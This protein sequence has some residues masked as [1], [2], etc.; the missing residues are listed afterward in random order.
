MSAPIAGQE[1]WSLSSLLVAQPLD[2]QL[3]FIVHYQGDFIKYGEW[4]KV[5]P[6][7]TENGRRHWVHTVMN[8]HFALCLIRANEWAKL[9][10]FENNLVVRAL[11]HIKAHVLAGIQSPLP[12]MSPAFAAAVPALPGGLAWQP[13]GPGAPP[14]PSS[15]PLPADGQT[16]EDTR[17]PSA[18]APAFE[19][20][21]AEAIDPTAGQQLHLL[22]RLLDPQAAPAEGGPKAALGAA[23]P[24]QPAGD[25]TIEDLAA[26]VRQLSV[27]AADA[28][29]QPAGAPPLPQPQATYQY[30][31]GRQPA[32]VGAL[33][34]DG[35]TPGA[36]AGVTAQALAPAQLLVHFD[37][38]LAEIRERSYYDGLSTEFLHLIYGLVAQ[39]W[40]DLTTPVC[41]HYLSQASAAQPRGQRRTRRRAR[42][43]DQAS[44]PGGGPSGAPGPAGQAPP[45]GAPQGG[46][47]MGARGNPGLY[48][49]GV[50]PMG[51]MMPGMLPQVIN[52]P[53]A[54][55]M[56]GAQVPQPW[57]AS[58]PPGSYPAPSAPA[59]TYGMVP[60]PHASVPFQPVA[61]DVSGGWAPTPQGL[62]AVSTAQYPPAS[63]GIP[64]PGGGASPGGGV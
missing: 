39:V 30:H 15:K 56:P 38:F 46:M 41:L 59:M 10:R 16:P 32:G 13:P 51:M 11:H 9:M 49:G 17:R 28:A 34:P 14:G 3:F 21:P 24:S 33:A 43:A 25:P 54:Q 20:G 42:P 35:A 52:I 7:D 27:G 62:A 2:I 1:G 37:S 44:W 55:M 45:M 31:Q 57:M 4:A 61:Q 29:A 64:P 22:S 58:L 12:A 48:G 26:S 5:A 60:H 63:G 47:G 36:G 23:G 8:A 18:G 50:A 53:A 40:C 6:C 19:R